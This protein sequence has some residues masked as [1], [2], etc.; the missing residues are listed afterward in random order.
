MK[1][2][3]NIAHKTQTGMSLI[4]FVLLVALLVFVAY[5]G[6]KIVPIYVEYYSVV[7]AMKGVQAEPDIGEKSAR[8]VKEL[9][10]RRLEISYVDSLGRDAVKVV[11]RGGKRL[12]VDYEVRKNILGNLDVVTHFKNDVLLR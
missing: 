1:A 4:G 2:E 9:L 7:S 12:E 11:Q 8:E 6:I 5:I 3:Y 10:Y